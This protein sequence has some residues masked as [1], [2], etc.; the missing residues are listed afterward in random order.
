M[1]NCTP[2][3]IPG[4]YTGEAQG[5]GGL[6][7]AAV[8]VDEREIVSVEA[9][10]SCETQKL[11]YLPKTVLTQRIAEHGGT[12]VDGISGATMTSDAIKMAVDKALSKARLEKSGRALLKPGVYQTEAMGYGGPVQVRT[13][14]SGRGIEAVEVTAAHETP[15]IGQVVLEKMAAKISDGNSL[16]VD[17]VSGATVT[18]AAI[19]KAVAGAIRQAGGDPADYQSR[20]VPQEKAERKLDVDVV[21]IGAGIAGYC[22]AIEAVDQGAQVLLLEKLDIIGGTAIVAGGAFMATNSYLNKERGDESKELADWWY[23][24]QE[25]HYNINYDQLL[26]VTRNSGAL[27]DWVRD[28]SGVEFQLGYGGGSAKMWSHRPVLLPEEPRNGHGTPRIIWGM[29][30]YFEEHGGT[31]LLGTKA[32]ELLSDE[33]G[34]VTGVK[35]E[36][37][38][39]RYTVHAAGGVIITT[40][41][42]EANQEL[43]RLFAPNSAHMV[44]NGYTAG[45]TGDGIL[46]GERVGAKLSYSGYLM[47][48][49]NHIE[50]VGAFGI[51]ALNLKHQSKCIEINGR[52][53]RFYNENTTP[54]QEKWA[55]AK[56]GTGE[57]YVL[58]DSSLSA[59]ILSKFDQAVRA[60]V[61]W[62]SDDIGG[63]AAAIGKSPLALERTVERWNELADSGVDLDFGNKLIA[64][65]DQGPYYLGRV[66]EMSTGSYGGL[67][68]SLQAEV[69][70]QDKK[71]IQGLYAAGESAN[72][73][74]FYRNYV[75]GG[76]SF[77]MCG[78][79][80]RT[81]GKNA[82]KRRLETR[83]AD[84]AGNI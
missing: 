25:R 62:K 11:A 77:A 63:L 40:G 51:D 2:I 56:D 58:F 4:A 1:G 71:P 8:T 53:E 39:T 3:Y 67:T 54:I 22:A 75:C 17:G 29:N 16:A 35:A 19:K 18:C 6:V 57:F 50:G 82:A 48:S 33:Q 81:A 23:D 73:E 55:F 44:S 12:D 59:D 43:V 26:Y 36:N 20:A 61:L 41:G 28:K 76:S 69:L 9:D 79:F 14:L 37:T 15:G 30:R 74:F 47:G 60:G 46:M 27:V 65:L 78:V 34:A 24:C 31:L 32:T 52:M 42:Y 66:Y 10:V 38:S 13:T 80:G 49:W 45:D 21:V 64:P 68:I 5:Y 70:G 7:K 72:G 83:S 84:C